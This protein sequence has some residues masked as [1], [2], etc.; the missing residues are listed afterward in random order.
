MSLAWQVV[1]KD[2]RRLRLPLLAWACLIT[3]QHAARWRLLHS[4]AADDRL[5][6]QWMTWFVLVLACVGLGVGYV[7]A[8]GVVMEDPAAGS[9]AFWKSRP[10]SGARMFGAKLLGCFVLLVIAPLVMGMPWWL[11]GSHGTGAGIATLSGALCWHAVAAGAGVVVA[12]FSATAGQ[13]LAW[14]VGLQGVVLFALGSLWDRNSQSFSRLLASFHAAPLGIAAAVLMVTM[15]LGA[16]VLASYQ[17]RPPRTV[18]SIL[19][20]GAAGAS[21]LLLQVLG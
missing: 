6:V 16:A 3:A 11:A 12:T 21:M 13:F 20:V 18:Y 15:A 17:R 5:Q 7:L 4:I 1:R 14:T 9:T 8:A 2:A 19:T 10:I